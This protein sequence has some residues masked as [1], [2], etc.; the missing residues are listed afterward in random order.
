MNLNKMNLID[1]YIL[2]KMYLIDLKILKDLSCWQWSNKKGF[3]VELAHRF[4]C[5]K[6]HDDDVCESQTSKNTN[7]FVS[8]QTDRYIDR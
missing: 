2:N 3:D 6:I 7:K 5:A 1:L 4:G 8:R